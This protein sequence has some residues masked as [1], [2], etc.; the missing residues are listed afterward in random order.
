[1]AMNTKLS[2]PRASEMI[3]KV[4][5]LAVVLC[6]GVLVVFTCSIADDATAV[7]FENG[8]PQIVDVYGGSLIVED[9]APGED[10]RH[11][12]LKYDSTETYEVRD[13]NGGIV[14]SVTLTWEQ[15]EAQGFR[16][17]FEKSDP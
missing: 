3:V 10:Y 1:M 9:L 7:T 6:A 2:A 11:M 14:A 8:L 4:A 16:I 17:V 13:Q 5:I 12:V 15:L